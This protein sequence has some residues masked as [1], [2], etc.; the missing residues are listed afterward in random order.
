[1][2][3]SSLEENT[4]TADCD[5]DWGND[6]ADRRSTTGFI[7]FHNRNPVSWSSKKQPTVASSTTEAEYMALSH[8]CQE[9]IWLR[10]LTSEL[11]PTSVEEPTTLYN[12]NKGAVDLASDAGSVKELN[13]SISD[14][15]SYV[16][17]SKMRRS[18]SSSSLPKT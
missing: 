8:T 18:K 3:F 9:L 1:M 5:A 15:I 11:D 6:L 10:F 4:I 13:I 16:N 17:W 12:D 7:I 14:T 2:E